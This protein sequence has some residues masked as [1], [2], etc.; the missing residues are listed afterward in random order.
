MTW[1]SMD[2]EALM[3][4]RQKWGLGFVLLWFVGGGVFHFVPVGHAFFTS[5]VPPWL[6]A[7]LPGPGALVYLSGIMELVAAAALL[8]EKTRRVAGY[9]LMAIT[10]GVTPANVHMWM[11]PELY[12]YAPQWMYAF[13]LLLQIFLL[14]LIWWS[15]RPASAWRPRSAA[16][17]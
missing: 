2:W 17:C 16:S 10:V 1:Q 15:T 7:W 13:R 3:P 9:A 6:P 11:H 5:I 4:V 8:R 12:A 14:W